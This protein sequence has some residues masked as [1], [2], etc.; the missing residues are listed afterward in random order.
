VGG[1]EDRVGRLRGG[2]EGEIL[3]EVCACG[4]VKGV[5]REGLHAVT[6]IVYK[7]S[8]CGEAA[9]LHIHSGWST[10]V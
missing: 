1:G 8:G 6:V 2:T 9:A 7:M 10:E 5:P 4:G 3:L